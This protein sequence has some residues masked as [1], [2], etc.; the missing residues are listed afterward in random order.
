[1][2]SEHHVI[3]CTLLLTTLFAIKRRLSCVEIS[4]YLQK[5][6]LTIFFNILSS[7]ALLIVMLLML[8]ERGAEYE[9]RI[10]ARNGVDFGS[11]EAEVIKTPDGRK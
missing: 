5:L 9:F 7:D 2:D 3:A 4:T 6:R 11:Y 8:V 1:M 10:A